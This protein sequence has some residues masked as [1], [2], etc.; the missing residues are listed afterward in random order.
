MNDA[1]LNLDSEISSDSDDSESWHSYLT[2]DSLPQSLPLEDY[3]VDVL[4][5]GGEDGGGED[6][7]EG[8]TPD[9]MGGLDDKAKVCL[10]VSLCNL[11]MTGN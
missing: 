5:D 7:A 4:I 2:A 10:Q 9:P 3:G 8:C 1:L 11:S 6:Q